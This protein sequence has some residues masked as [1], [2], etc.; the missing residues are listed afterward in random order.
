[1]RGGL[2][3][4]CES[5]YCFEGKFANITT[6]HELNWN[7][8]DCTDKLENVHIHVC[9]FEWSLNGIENLILQLFV[10]VVQAV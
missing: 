9:V 5:K 4:A 3:I 7:W 6:T 2:E 8:R 1:M 10:P